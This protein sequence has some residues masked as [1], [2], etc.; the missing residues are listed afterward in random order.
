MSLGTIHV[1]DVRAGDDRCR[2]EADIHHEPQ[3]VR[4]EVEADLRQMGWDVGACPEALGGTFGTRRLGVPPTQRASDNGVG[5]AG[6]IAGEAPPGYVL[7]WSHQQKLAAV[8]PD[9]I[10]CVAL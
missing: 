3:D 6:A 9:E 4:F 5:N 1:A 7:V 10:R 2:P 8:D